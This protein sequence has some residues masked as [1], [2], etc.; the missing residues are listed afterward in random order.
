MTHICVGKLITIGS[1]NVLSPGRRQAVIWTNAAILLI[2]PLGTNFGEILIALE[3]FSFNK[4]HLKISSA[5]WRSFCLGFKVLIV[6][7]ILTTDSKVRSPVTTVLFYFQSCLKFC[8]SHC[9]DAWNL[10]V[11]WTTLLKHLHLCYLRSQRPFSLS[12]WN[13]LQIGVNKRLVVLVTGA[14]TVYCIYC[15]RKSLCYIL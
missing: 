11:Y 8:L 9:L 1:D 6:S 7:K 4:M 2:G 10:M 3:A 15:S 5:K 13:M 14:A 12:L